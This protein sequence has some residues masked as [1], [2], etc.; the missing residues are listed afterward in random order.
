MNRSEYNRLSS[1]F[2]SHLARSLYLFIIKPKSD[3]SGRYTIDYAVLIHELS[4][5]ALDSNE[6]IYRPGT[7]EVT[8]AILNLVKIQLLTINA[9]LDSEHFQNAVVTVISKVHN[10]G[11]KMAS[12]A[13]LR[14]RQHRFAMRADWLPSEQFAELARTG[15]LINHQYREAEIAEFRSYWISRGSLNNES[16]WDYKF[17]QYLKRRHSRTA[18]IT[19]IYTDTIGLQ[20]K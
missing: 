6:L 2:L 17:I 4:V 3:A 5:F 15:M 10:S 7:E 16:E 20:N 18:S 12:T 8:A 13:R 9:A 14:Q 11:E 1:P 19:P